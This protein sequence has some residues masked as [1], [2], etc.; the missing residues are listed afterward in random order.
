M[1]AISLIFVVVFDLAVWLLLL[2]YSVILTEPMVIGSSYKTTRADDR[3]ADGAFYAS[4]VAFTAA[5]L[6]A[7]CA[8]V[9]G[10]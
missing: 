5:W 3:L 4:C 7:G 2:A 9:F 8:M 1:S 6:A 10:W